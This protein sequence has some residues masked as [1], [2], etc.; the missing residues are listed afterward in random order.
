MHEI[1]AGIR[2]A[3][4]ISKIEKDKAEKFFGQKYW[5]NIKKNPDETDEDFENRLANAK[6]SLCVKLTCENGATA[7]IQLPKG[8]QFHPKSKMSM[9]KKIYGGMPKVNMTVNTQTDANGYYKV[10]I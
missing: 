6:D 4:K 8:T 10:I 2:T 5:E 7:I 9:F 3:T 1:Q